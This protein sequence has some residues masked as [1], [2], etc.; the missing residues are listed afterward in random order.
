MLEIVAGLLDTK[1]ADANYHSLFRLCK[2]LFGTD[3]NT[4]V[5][6]MHTGV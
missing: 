2:Q 4:T 1:V 5:Q 6:F 3:T